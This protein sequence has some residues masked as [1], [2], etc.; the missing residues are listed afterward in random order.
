MFSCQTD[1]DLDELKTMSQEE[2]NVSKSNLKS[3]SCLQVVKEFTDE[4]G[5]CVFEVGQVL[6]GLGDFELGSSDPSVEIRE[7]RRSGNTWFVTACEEGDF[8]VT[9]FCLKT[10]GAFT[11][12]APQCSLELTCEEEEIEDPQDE[13]CE[14]FCVEPTLISTD[15]NC[16]SFRFI[17]PTACLGRT[18]FVLN[19]SCGLF[20]HI[21][22]AENG[23]KLF[24]A[25]VCSSFGETPMSEFV[26][27]GTLE[28]ENCGDI[29]VGP[30]AVFAP[31]FEGAPGVC[32]T[33]IDY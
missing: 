18:E 7:N 2:V 17:I 25:T 22:Y 26:L 31:D 11:Y 5:C 29:Q 23:F 10:S 9:L 20:N 16:L 15:G 1:S 8:E 30:A 32:S 24:T 33:R 3:S 19:A 6:L 21:A 12:W 4:N 28:T 14:D 13:C 27:K